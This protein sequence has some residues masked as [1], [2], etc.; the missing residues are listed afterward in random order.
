MEGSARPSGPS[1]LGG[2]G[3]SAEAGHQGDGAALGPGSGCE[4]Q[5]GVALEQKARGVRTEPQGRMPE[6]RRGMGKGP[7]MNAH[8]PSHC[9]AQPST[10]TVR[11]ARGRFSNEGVCLD[12]EPK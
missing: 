1:E 8:C 3:G 9:K 6:R 12:T 10:V 11:L 7:Q 5:L 4:G 2:V